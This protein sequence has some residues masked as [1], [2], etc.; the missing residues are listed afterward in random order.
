MS[1]ATKVLPAPVIGPPEDDPLSLLLE[2]HAATPRAI[3]PQAKIAST[4]LREINEAPSW[5]KFR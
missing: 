4:D 2:P 1:G 5:S 3:T